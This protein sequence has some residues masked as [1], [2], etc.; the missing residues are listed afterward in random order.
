MDKLSQILRDV[1]ASHSKITLLLGAILFVGG[2][3]GGVTYNSWLPIPDQ[4]AQLSLMVAGAVLIATSFF[5]ITPAK[6]LKS[7]ELAK[8]GI[9]ITAPHA[10]ERIKGKVRVTVTSSG[11]VPEGYELHVLRG[12][13]KVSGVVP[14][15]KVHKTA[16]KLE[17]VAHDFDIGGT[18]GETRTIEV[19]LVG[20]G[21]LA[22]LANWEA[23]HKVV[24]EANRS[25][26]TLGQNN[27]N[28]L[29]PIT[30]FTP[31]MYRCQSVVVARSN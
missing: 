23:N 4:W 25:L 7:D 10:G 18:T 15:T 3:A 26:K 20:A 28:W 11:Q 1:L 13:P 24:S 14:N 29:P 22:L 2:A 27:L 16:E 21:G 31:D 8:L 30:R 9:Q 19:W 12:Y 17:W 5:T 6:G